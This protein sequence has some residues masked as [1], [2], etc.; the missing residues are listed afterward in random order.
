MELREATRGMSSEQVRA[1]GDDELIEAVFIP[2]VPLI[3]RMIF[4]FL[5]EFTPS[6]QVIAQYAPVS[7]DRYKLDMLARDRGFDLTRYD[8]IV[9][10]WCNRWVEAINDKL[11]RRSSKRRG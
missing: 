9:N 7:V 1:T 3:S 4:E 11:N 10:R 8:I 6:C 5:Y 2:E